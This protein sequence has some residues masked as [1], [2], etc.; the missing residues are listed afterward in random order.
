MRG[1]QQRA[2]REH[3]ARKW[4]AWHTAVLVRTPRFPK[5]DDF[6]GSRS[7]TKGKTRQSPDDVARNLKLLGAAWNAERVH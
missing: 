3:E 2:E 4:A 7:S 5:F 6:A 1:A